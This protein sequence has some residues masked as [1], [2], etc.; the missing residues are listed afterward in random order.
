[1]TFLDYVVRVC[2]F[3]W[4]FVLVAMQVLDGFEERT[5]HL[6]WLHW[7]WRELFASACIVL[8]VAIVSSVI[9]LGA[10]ALRL[11]HVAIITPLPPFPK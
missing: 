6:K 4:V 11:I 8:A 5:K 10:G 7:F 2:I 9:L 3:S 1:M